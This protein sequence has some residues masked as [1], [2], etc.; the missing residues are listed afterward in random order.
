MAIR[1]I[2]HYPDKR[3][4]IPG[5]RVTD[6]GPELQTL[7]DDMAE[8]MYAAPGVG[9]AAT[10]IGVALRVFIIDVATGDDEPSDLRVFVNPEILE[11]NG[12]VVWEEGCLSFPGVHE[13]IDRA[14]RVKVRAQDRNGQVFELE[15]DGLLAVAVQHENDHLEGKLMVDHLGMLKKRMVHRQM[16]KRAADAA[17]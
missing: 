4:R 6:F 16:M 11:R 13:E 8:T 5:E 10:Q 7:V 9:L 17:E 3:L 1:T 12:E 15:A 2:L 14:E